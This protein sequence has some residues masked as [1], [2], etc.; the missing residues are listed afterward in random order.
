MSDKYIYIT[1]Y[2]TVVKGDGDE[3][4]LN[5]RQTNLKHEVASG[6]TADDVEYDGKLKF[7]YRFSNE[8][9]IFIGNNIEISYPK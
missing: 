1:V 6:A 4:E 5:T 8:K 9:R 7:S 2:F 3:T